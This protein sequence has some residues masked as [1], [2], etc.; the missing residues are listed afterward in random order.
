[1][2][3]KFFR[4]VFK[5]FIVILTLIVAFMAF[6]LSN[7]Q[8]RYKYN[9]DFITVMGQEYYFDNSLFLHSEREFCSVSAGTTYEELVKKFGR[10]NGQL[11][12]NAIKDAI[13]YALAEDRFI[14]FR[15]IPYYSYE[16]GEKNRSL[17]VWCM[18]LCDD[19]EP[20]EILYE[21]R[22][23]CDTAVQTWEED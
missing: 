23:V 10:E 2:V 13:Y 1:M 4:I 20:L 14:V 12:S 17:I 3:K 9:H 18:Y 8:V 16:G 19:K 6:L 15:L 11:N 5:I 21:D 22:G 7:W